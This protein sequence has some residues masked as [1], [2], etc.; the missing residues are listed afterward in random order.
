MG[1]R[2]PRGTQ[3]SLGTYGAQQS[4]PSKFLV[5]IILKVCPH[6]LVNK[7][8]LLEFRQFFLGVSGFLALWPKWISAMAWVIASCCPTSTRKHHGNIA[9]ATFFFLCTLFLSVLLIDCSGL[10]PSLWN[11]LSPPQR[12]FSREAQWISP[13]VVSCLVSG[14]YARHCSWGHVCVCVCV[15]FLTI[16]Y[17]TITIHIF[18]TE[19]PLKCF[20]MCHHYE[21]AC[22]SPLRKTKA[23]G[24]IFSLE[25]RWF[26][27]LYFV[28]VHR[29]AGFQ[30][31][32]SFSVFLLF[33]CFWDIYSQCSHAVLA[34]LELLPRII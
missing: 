34:I 14:E 21:V 11:P 23:Q 20:F 24:V 8:L 9:D 19:E 31:E 27:S 28:N 16:T 10:S 7:M 18:I 17:L 25:V 6:Y 22:F 33:G 32:V 13:P 26:V 12:I 30:C 15:Y 4:A 29:N 3:I 2:T 1:L 5:T